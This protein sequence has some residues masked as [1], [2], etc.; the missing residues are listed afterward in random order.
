MSSF[1]D[2]ENR[3]LINEPLRA[4]QFYVVTLEEGM[5][6]RE[7]MAWLLD[8]LAEKKGDR[9]FNNRADVAPSSLGRYLPHITILE[10]LYDDAG[11]V[12][13]A[14]YR[15]MGTEIS[16]LYGEATGKLVSDYHGE[17]VR[18][19]VCK[20]SNHCLESGKPALGLS[21]ALSDGRQFV[22]VSVL[23]FPLSA[24]DETVDQFFIYS[25]VERNP[26]GGF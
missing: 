15:L 14:R 7:D 3:R 4:D 8:R 24:D 23:Y 11:L 13:D 21:K 18:R 22:D 2:D 19:R 16:A 10:P 1:G 20:I 12:V 5:A 9:R 26:M 6:I 17:D 25:A